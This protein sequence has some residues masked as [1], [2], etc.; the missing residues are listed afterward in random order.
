MFNGGDPVS[1]HQHCRVRIA[2]QW[3]QSFARDHCV[4]W[5]CFFFWNYCR[6][7]TLVFCLKQPA[8]LQWPCK[9]QQ[10]SCIVGVQLSPRRGSKVE[11]G[12]FWE[13][14]SHFTW[15]KFKMLSGKCRM[16]YKVSKVVQNKIGTMSVQ[17][18]PNFTVNSKT[19]WTAQRF[20][21]WSSMK[22]WPWL[23]VYRVGALTQ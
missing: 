3:S 4:F 23:L 21:F 16:N 2:S 1:L 18:K 19:C 11:S 9:G 20:L 5:N 22:C 12:T 14:K 17:G 6:C 15:G 13:A 10:D 8:G 7:S